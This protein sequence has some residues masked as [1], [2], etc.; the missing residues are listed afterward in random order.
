M[1]TQKKVNE[2]CQ[3]VNLD[4]SSITIGKVHALLDKRYSFLTLANKV[5]LF[6]ENPKR[7][8][9]VAD[10]ELK[11]QLTQPTKGLAEKVYDTL[12]L[13]NKKLKL[14]MDEEKNVSIVL[15]KYLQSYISKC[16]EKDTQVY[17][18]RAKKIQLN[19]DHLEVRYFGLR[20]RYQKLLEHYDILKDQCYYLEQELQNVKLGKRNLDN[21][22]L[23]KREK[24]VVQMRDAKM[25]LSLLKGECC[26][27]Y[28]PTNK[29]IVVKLPVRH[30]L[31][32]ELEKGPRSIHL[33]ANA[34]YDFSS[35][36]WLLKGFEAQTINLLTRNNFVISKELSLVLRYLQT[37]SNED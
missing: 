12:R 26:A 20:T 9:E 4:G 8:K 32:R 11:A 27:A 18:D 25:Q 34:T 7:A 30:K 22:N 2:I 35:K 23:G 6:K 14:G 19:N 29:Q 31:I 5:I 10:K 36:S 16:I 13:I 28:D 3:M 33:R 1:L 15:T 24:K 37:Q 21:S 17:I